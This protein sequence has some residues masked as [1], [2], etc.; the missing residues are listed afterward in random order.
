[1]DKETFIEAAWP[2]IG[3]RVSEAA[4]L[5]DIYE[6][7]K[8]SVGLPVASDSDA[9]RMFRLVLAH[10]RSLIQSRNLIE[11]R[12]AGL[13]AEHPDYQLLRSIPASDRSMRSRCWPR[14]ARLAPVP[15]P[16]AGPEVLRLG[17]ATVQ[18]GPFRGRSKIS[19]YGNARLRRTLWLAGQAAVLSPAN[20]FRDKFERT[21]SQDHHN[22]DRRRKAHTA[23]AA[24]MARAIHAV[25]KSGEPYRPFFDGVSPH[26]KTPPCRAVEAGF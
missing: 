11:A 25:I 2:V 10:G 12:V 1:M 23:I 6:A 19:T 22:P 21:I 13:L 20:S 9:I 8:A 24:K 15:A 14:P 17:L 7:A 18:S 3:R 16:P 5:A 4:L 26:G